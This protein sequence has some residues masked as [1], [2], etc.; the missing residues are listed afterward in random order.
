MAKK[1]LL[2]L[3]VIV[4]WYLWFALGFGDLE[5][6]EPGTA[7]G[8][9]MAIVFFVFIIQKIFQK[10]KTNNSGE[11]ESKEETKESGK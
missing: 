6:F 10:K 2:I 5:H 4:A 8:K 7:I 1:I 3:V 11:K 9:I